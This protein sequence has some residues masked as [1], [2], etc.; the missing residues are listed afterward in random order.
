MSRSGN[1]AVEAF[2]R[3]HAGLLLRSYRHWTGEPLAPEATADPA[4]W[5]YHA[6]FALLS[7]GGGA[8]PVF[9]YANLSAQRL[10]E[11]PWEVFVGLPSRLSAEADARTA[12][13]ALLRQVREKGFADDYQG[14]RV[15][16]SG[17]RF[18]IRN[19]KVWNLLAENGEHRGQAACFDQWRFLDSP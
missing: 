17:R 19:V 16:A 2:R 12:R 13:E 3:A 6:P 1:D 18:A 9:N 7:H 4:R 15:A 5:L 8:D 14:I 11:Y 10:F